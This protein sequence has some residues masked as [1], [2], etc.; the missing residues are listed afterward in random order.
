M[1]Y[2]AID[3][4]NTMKNTKKSID[5]IKE[6]YQLGAYKYLNEVT[7]NNDDIFQNTKF[8]YK[9]RFDN[10]NIKILKSVKTLDK[11]DQY[12]IKKY[13]IDNVSLSNMRE[14]IDCDFIISKSYERFSKIILKLS[15]SVNELIV[16]KKE[17]EEL[18]C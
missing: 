6:L 2:P 12:I 4:N 18:P 1:I 16:Y 11:L 8:C 17:Q 13:C 3:I 9:T 14:G 10:I 5:I 7:Y 15:Y